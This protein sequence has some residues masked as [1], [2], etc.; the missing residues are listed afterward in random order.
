MIPCSETT[1]R[2]SVTGGGQEDGGTEGQGD[3]RTGVCEAGQSDHVSAPL[4]ALGNLPS[5]L[6]LAYRRNVSAFFTT[7]SIFV[8][9]PRSP[10]LHFLKL[11]FG[12]RWI[13]VFFFM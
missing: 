10:S 9:R 7:D 3:G 5:R 1:C 12:R 8:L 2:R 11:D 4:L 13:F 6:R